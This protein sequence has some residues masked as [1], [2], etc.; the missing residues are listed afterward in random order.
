MEDFIVL[1]LIVFLICVFYMIIAYDKNV[2]L[3]QL[4]TACFLI[5]NIFFWLMFSLVNVIDYLIGG[6]K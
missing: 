6:V 1:Q 5:P 3:K 4:L 2:N